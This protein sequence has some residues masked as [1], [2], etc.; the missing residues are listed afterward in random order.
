LVG[1]LLVVACIQSGPSYLLGLDKRTGEQVWKQDRTLDAPDESNQTY[2]TPVVA[3][4]DGKTILVVLGADHVT[5]HDSATGAE[6]W[7]VGGLNPEGERF[8]RS[9]ASPIVADGIA[10]APY[11]RGS[12]LTAI[13]LGG[14]G[15]VTESHVIWKKE[16]ISSDVPT[17]AVANGRLYVCGDRGKVA[18]L[19]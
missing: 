2:S 16:G 15:D 1:D 12:T 9:I 11:A 18:C 13:R 10:V 14:S 4:H 6:L 17:P 7:R 3:Q 19:D 8:F 5:A